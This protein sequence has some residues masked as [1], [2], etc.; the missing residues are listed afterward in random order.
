MGNHYHGGHQS[1]GEVEDLTGHLPGV[2]RRLD[3]YRSTSTLNGGRIKP[4]AKS[5][6]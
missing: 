1:E 6:K 4:I 3:D 5:S 2:S